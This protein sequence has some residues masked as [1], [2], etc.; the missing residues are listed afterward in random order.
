MATKTGFVDLLCGCLAKPQYFGYVTAT[1][2]VSP[3]RSMAAFAGRTLVTVHQSKAGM[4]IGTEFL[5]D[6]GMAGL[7]GLRPDEVGRV[8]GGRP[9]R[10]SGLLLLLAGSVDRPG[11]PKSGHQRNQCDTYEQTLHLAPLRKGSAQIFIPMIC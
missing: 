3:A 7:A 8:G 1:L 2:D 4:G 11:F 6:L 9:L 5:G 10:Q